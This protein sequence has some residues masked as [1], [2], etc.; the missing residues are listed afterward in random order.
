[1]ERAGCFPRQAWRLRKR[2]PWFEYPQQL[3]GIAIRLQCLFPVVY[4]GSMTLAGIVPAL[5]TPLLSDES[6]DEAG[7]RRL[8]EYLV[9]AKVNGVLANGSMG[10]FAFLTDDEQIRAI[11]IS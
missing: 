9:A 3:I 8:V 10:G 4:S 7:L 1:M 5:G 6:V 11:G 2:L